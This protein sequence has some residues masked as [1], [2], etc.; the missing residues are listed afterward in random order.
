[1]IWHFVAN[2]YFLTKSKNHFKPF[3][4][5]HL[6]NVSLLWGMNTYAYISVYVLF[7]DENLLDLTVGGGMGF[8][9]GKFQRKIFCMN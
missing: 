3:Q 2:K 6:C 1:M 4:K 5:W 8:S 7:E 9:K